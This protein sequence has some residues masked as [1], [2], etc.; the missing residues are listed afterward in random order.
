MV[1][2]A[3]ETPKVCGYHNLEALHVQF[4]WAVLVTSMLVVISAIDVIGL[5]RLNLLR[6]AALICFCMCDVLRQFLDLACEM[7]T[8]RHPPTVPVFAELGFINDW[9]WIR[10]G[11]T[12]IQIVFLR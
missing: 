7:Q 1:A 10:K 3:Q 6:D 12:L 8:L 2:S 5:R 9:L 4:D 11:A